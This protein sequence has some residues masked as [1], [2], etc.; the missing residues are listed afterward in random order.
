MEQPVI[1]AKSD[2]SAES[3]A[4]A[5]NSTAY[6]TTPYSRQATQSKANITDRETVSSCKN[7]RENQLHGK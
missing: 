7:K 2:F 6:N 3:C 5:R 1:I 4:A